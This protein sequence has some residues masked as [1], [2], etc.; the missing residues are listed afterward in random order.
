METI[1]VRR[2]RDLGAVIRAVRE[3]RGIRQEDLAGELAFSRDYLR[4]LEDGKPTLYITR[5]FRVLNALGIR[6]TVTYGLAP[7]RESDE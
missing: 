1:R 4:G 2:F 5:L 7:P 3:S 6:V